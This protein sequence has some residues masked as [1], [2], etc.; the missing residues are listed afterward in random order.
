MA[1]NI[2]TPREYFQLAYGQPFEKEFYII[3]LSYK[4]E[5]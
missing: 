4:S 3:K 2:T 1:V 5:N